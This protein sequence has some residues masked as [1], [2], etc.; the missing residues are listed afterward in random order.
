[1]HYLENVTLLGIDCIDIDRLIFAADVSEKYIKFKTVKLLTHLDSSDDRIVKIPKIDTIEA[2]SEFMIKHLDTYVDTD[3]V[4]T[5]QYDGFIVNPEQWKQE[6]LQ[7]DYIGAPTKWGMGNGGFSLRSKKLLQLLSED[8]HITFVHPEDIRICRTY[9]SYLESKGIKFA[10]LE[11]AHDFSVENG[12]WNH[13]F[14]FHNA[15]IS[16]WEIEKFADSVKHAAYISHHQKYYVNTDIRLTYI[17]Q[18]YLEDNEYNPIQELIDIYSRYNPEVI[19]KIHFVFVDDASKSPIEIAEDVNLNYTLVRINE[20]IPW[21]QPG[22]RNL[23]V[24][25]AKS[26]NI[27]VTDLDIFFPENLLESLLYFHPPRNSIFKFRTFA[28]LK[29]VDAHFNVFFMNKEVFHRTNGVDEEF[30][31]AYGQ[32]DVFFYFLQKAIGTKFYLYS[33]SN[34]VH[35]EHKYH[36]HTQHNPLIRDTARNLKILDRKMKIVRSGDRDPLEARSD[37]Y[38]NFTWKVL[39]EN[40]I[41]M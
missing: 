10:P 32:D 33:Y 23:G 37:L 8:D 28:G 6:F 9:R 40:F 2:Y 30:S 18:F 20:D 21:N 38:L 5:I 13:Q 25:F 29:P 14:G 19:K 41:E 27:V 4:L 12:I 7:Y 36:K 3:F 31:G 35:K 24:T 1:M 26:E 17:V 11:L 39:Q 34:I 15:D 22:A 16:A